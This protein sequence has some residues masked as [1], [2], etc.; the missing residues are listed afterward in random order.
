MQFNCSELWWELKDRWESGGCCPEAIGP[1]EPE[2]PNRRGQERIPDGGEIRSDRTIAVLA[3]LQQQ[4]FKR[5]KNTH[6][7]LCETEL[8]WRSKV[9]EIGTSGTIHKVCHVKK[10]MKVRTAVVNSAAWTPIRLAAHVGLKKADG[11]SLPR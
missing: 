2:Q 8:K 1:A 5:L 4:D 6:E 3:E 11:H 7:F 9:H 10:P